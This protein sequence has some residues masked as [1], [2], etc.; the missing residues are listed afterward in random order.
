[1]K[2]FCIG[3][4]KTGTT[5]MFLEFHRL[6][7][8]TNGRRDGFSE[9]LKYYLNNDFNY[10]VDYCKDYDAFQDV[11]FSLPETYEHLNKRYQDSKFILTIRDSPEVWYNS[12]IRHYSQVFGKNGRIP[13]KEDLQNHSYTHLGWMWKLNRKL[14]DTPES[15]P[16]K[17][18][19]MIDWYNT[20]NKNVIDYFKDKENFLVLNLK[21]KESYKKFTDFLEIESPFKTFLHTNR[22]Q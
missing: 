11:P 2:I 21:E 6:G 15:E 3:A 18:D 7:F 19:K 10:I 4:N 17:K 1:M 13:T 12:L 16:Y 14:Y 5:S 22:T 20:Y 9:L 8:K